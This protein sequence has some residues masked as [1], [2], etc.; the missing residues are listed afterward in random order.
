[1]QP[2]AHMSIGE[3]YTHDLRSTSGA[4]YLH[5]HTHQ[6]VSIGLVLIY[7]KLRNKFIVLFHQHVIQSSLE[8][9]FSARFT[10]KI[11]SEELAY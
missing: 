5:A 10:R 2:T 4:R 8:L 6:D 11:H 1:M 3:L 9:F 7:K